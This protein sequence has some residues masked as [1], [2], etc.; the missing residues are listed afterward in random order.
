M[1]TGAV[2][3][4]PEVEVVPWMGEVCALSGVEHALVTLFVHRKPPK[5]GLPARKWADDVGGPFVKKKL[6]TPPK[7]WL[8]E[9]HKMH[10]KNC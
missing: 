9:Y 10:P 3:I 8:D 6:Q 4:D 2:G 1:I 7:A 5:T